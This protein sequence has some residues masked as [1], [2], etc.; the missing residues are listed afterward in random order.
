MIKT[1]KN[2]KVYNIKNNTNILIINNNIINLL[3][4]TNNTFFY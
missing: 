1:K 3:Y 4:S 2:K